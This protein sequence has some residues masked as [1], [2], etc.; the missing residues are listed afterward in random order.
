[1]TQPSTDPLLFSHQSSSNCVWQDLYRG[2]GFAYL[3]CL[4][5]PHTL[6]PP[7]LISDCPVL[8]QTLTQAALWWCPSFYCWG[9]WDSL[10][11][12]SKIYTFKLEIFFADYFHNS[13][14]IVCSNMPEY[15]TGFN[16]MTIDWPTFFIFFFRI[17]GRYSSDSDSISSGCSAG[18]NC[19]YQLYSQSE[20]L[21]S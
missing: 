12:V 6:R 15:Y 3:S 21:C 20:C 10:L 7:V 18:R 1:M 14:I 8:S 11:R 4:T 2:R 9:C 5:A 16:K 17:Y 19:L 13:A